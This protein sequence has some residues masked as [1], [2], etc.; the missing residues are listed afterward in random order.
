MTR[1]A[2]KNVCELTASPEKRAQA[3]DLTESIRGNFPRGVGEP[4]LRA[5]ARA[6]YTTVQELRHVPDAELLA[7]HGVGP[8][9]IRVIRA[10]LEGTT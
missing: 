7:L 10:V 2:E 3:N 5:F 1:K 4:A 9:A 8:K 6:G